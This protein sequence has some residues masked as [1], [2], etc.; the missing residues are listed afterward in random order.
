MKKTSGELIREALENER[1]ALAADE[2]KR[3]VRL[4]EALK[5]GYYL[6]GDVKAYQVVNETI[7]TIE[8]NS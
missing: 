4:L 2:R 5:R 1:R 6:A 3:I 8:R 7:A